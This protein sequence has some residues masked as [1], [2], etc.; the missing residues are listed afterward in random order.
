MY[1]PDDP[2]GKRRHWQFRQQITHHTLYVGHTLYALR[3][4]RPSHILPVFVLAVTLG[5]PGLLR[6]QETI[7]LPEA[8]HATAGRLYD[9]RARMDSLLFDAGFVRCE[10]DEVMPL[11]LMMSSS[12]TITR[13]CGRETKCG[14]IFAGLRP[15]A[16]E[17]MV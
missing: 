2:V 9:E 13:D 8:G 1:A 10:A 3:R 4:L 16:L 5:A 15:T 11:S 6:S 7:W 14:R 12:I 17:G